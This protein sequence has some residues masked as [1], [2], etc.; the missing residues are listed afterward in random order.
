MSEYLCVLS[1]P[2]RPEEGVECSRTGV[3]NACVCWEINPESLEEQQMLLTTELSRQP[4]LWFFLYRQTIECIAHSIL[5]NKGWPMAFCISTSTYLLVCSRQVT[6]RS[7]A[8]KMTNTGVMLQ[9]SYYH[10]IL[11]GARCEDVC[12][13]FYRLAPP[14][15]RDLSSS[16][17]WDTQPVFQTN[18]KQNTKT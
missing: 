7:W 16:S 9:R 5:L 11:K 15:S 10:M 1:A 13:Q 4:H 3:T 6:S 14:D 2:W 18:K 12:W 8:T 17:D